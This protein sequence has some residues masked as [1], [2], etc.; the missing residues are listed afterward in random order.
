[1][2]ASPHDKVVLITGAS[3]GIGAACAELY[4]RNGYRLALG[5]RR[6]ER[7]TEAAVLLRQQGAADVLCMALDVCDVDSVAAFALEV[8][9]RYSAVDILINNAGLAAGLDPIATGKDE[10]WAAMIETNIYGLLRMTRRFLPGM[11]ARQRG[12]IV[13]IGSVAG[14]QTYANGAVYSGTKH[15]VRA[16]SGALRLELLGTAIRVSEVDPGMVETEFSS[17]RLQNEERAKAVYRGTVPLTGHDIA[18]CV[19]FATT[20]PPHVNVDHLLVMPTQQASVH[21]V[22]RVQNAT[23]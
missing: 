23:P 2:T 20:R 14:F 7:L 22:H 8:E 10:D 6:L 12:H 5:A 4:A 11:I 21:H 9:Q 13:N 15:A 3:A 19:Y 16:I 1:M 18:D 17:V